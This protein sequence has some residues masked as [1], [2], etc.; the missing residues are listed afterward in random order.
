MHAEHSKGGRNDGEDPFDLC[1]PR[2][3]PGLRRRSA[4]P[5][6]TLDQASGGQP[7]PVR[8][9]GP[10]RL[11]DADATVLSVGSKIREL[12]LTRE[13]TLVCPGSSGM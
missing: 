3:I 9:P 7:Q 8:D 12:R 6:M 2:T 13:L 10:R 5:T 11:L 1:E 4:V